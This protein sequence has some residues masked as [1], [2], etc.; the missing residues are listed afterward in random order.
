LLSWFS[1]KRLDEWGAE[2]NDKPDL[3]F[4]KRESTE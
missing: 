4:I 1:P 3:S 2:N